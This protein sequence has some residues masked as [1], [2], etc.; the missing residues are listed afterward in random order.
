MEELN[1]TVNRTCEEL[2][3]TSKYYLAFSFG[4]ET[5]Y[6]CGKMPSWDYIDVHIFIYSFL[7]KD[8]MVF[9]KEMEVLAGRGFNSTNWCSGSVA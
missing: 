9:F 1:I 4:N 3:K 7:Y 2:D 8:L 5:F 6:P